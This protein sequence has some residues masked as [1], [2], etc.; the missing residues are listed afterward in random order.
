M[1]ERTKR[2]R[3]R[4]KKNDPGWNLIIVVGTKRGTIIASVEQ[5]RGF[6]C[7]SFDRPDGRQPV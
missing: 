7:H 1:S 2:E 3:E 5:I 6:T 4:N